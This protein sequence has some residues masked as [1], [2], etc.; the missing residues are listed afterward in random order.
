VK[1]AYYTDVRVQAKSGEDISRRTTNSWTKTSGVDRRGQLLGLYT[2]ATG[3]E[4]FRAETSFFPQGAWI[5]IGDGTWR[6]LAYATTTKAV[7]EQSTAP[8][9]VSYWR[10][11]G[12]QAFAQT[13]F[14]P[15]ADPEERSVDG[16]VTADSNGSEC[17]DWATCQGAT[18]S[19]SVNDT[20]ATFATPV[21]IKETDRIVIRRG[22]FYFDT[23]S[24]GTADIIEA[25]T[26]SLFVTGTANDHND[27]N[28]FVSLVQ[29]QG[30]NVSST[31]SL[32]TGDYNDVGDTIDNP[33]EG[34]DSGQ[35]KDITS[36]TTSQYLDWTLNS[37][38]RSWIARS[39]EQN[40]TGGV[41][42]ITYLGVRE[43]HDLLDSEPGSNG[44]TELTVRHADNTGISEDPKLVVTHN[45][46]TTLKVRKAVNEDVISSSTLQNDD[47]LVLTLSANTTYI[48]D[49]SIFATSTSGT[50][51]IKIAFTLPTGAVMDL[52][53]E[54][55]SA[56]SLR[57]SEVLETSG[58]ASSNIPI[59][60]AAPTTI[61]IGGTIKMGGTGGNVTLQWAQNSANANP[62]TVMQGSYLRADE[63]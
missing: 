51:D 30:N 28:D 60:I 19:G 57:R 47:E 36:V 37:T 7:F 16:A 55:A 40:P 25:A 27:G 31:T 49:G 29:V 22:L 32:A 45:T 15:D 50:P 41:A 12:Q 56:Q 39:G 48:I 35:R 11:L 54:A 2:D 58:V 23:S 44:T 46:P 10:A 4:R 26:F 43:G 24:I 38:G 21:V 6:E 5:K 17:S 42:G 52:G 59:V 9:S 18:D 14:N 63:I 13:T 1:Y 34:H 8:Q 61:Q 3:E 20:I 62:T 53:F 33:T